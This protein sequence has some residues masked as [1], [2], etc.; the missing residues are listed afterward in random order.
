MK[1][2]FALY[3][4]CVLLSG[5]CS[6]LQDKDSVAS[7]TPDH[8]IRVSGISKDGYTLYLGDRFT[9]NPQI[10]F[11]DSTRA[12]DYDYRWII[13]KNEIISREKNLNWEIALPIDY[14]LNSEIPGVFVVH[15]TV[16]DLEFRQTFTLTL[17]TGYTPEY[18][19]I[20]ETDEGNIEWMS[21]QGT[22]YEWTR[23]YED[24]IERV[25][26]TTVPGPFIGAF[27]STDE[28]A[29]F[30][31]HEPDYG[32]TVSMIDAD[33]DDDFVANVGE[34]V[35]NIY[36]RVYL[37]N[38]SRLDIKDVTYGEGAS[39]YLISNGTLHVFNGL[40]KR[41]PMYDENT[42]IKSTEVAQ[43]VSSKQFM[44][45]KKATFVR[46]NDGRIGCFHTYNDQM[47]WITIGGEPFMLD[48]ICGCFTQATGE[49]SNKPYDV[50]LIG[51]RDNTYKIYRFHVDYIK[52]QVRPIVYDDSFDIPADLVEK[53]HYWFG[54]FGEE[55]A[56]YVTQDAIYRFDYHDMTTFT[57]ATAPLIQFDGDKEILD[58]FI[59]QG[60]TF[61]DEDDCTV[62][63]LY[64][65]KTRKTTLYVYDTVTG[66][67]YA[68]YIDLLPGRG[69]F[70]TAR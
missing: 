63:F 36:G 28:L 26:R 35:G 58:L 25:N 31:G 37:G 30:S 13:G 15:N 23:T 52:T 1:N 60:S 14:K 7:W 45:F 3:I 17:L 59:L 65:T 22:P 11:S 69:V 51:G 49:G 8:V 34:I 21:L 9:C 50:Y 27:N 19:A 10:T 70:F 56:F 20:Y 54:S 66:R 32:V 4:A 12:G 24:M 47:E 48:T 6:C 40:E 46:H 42:Y 43:T 5:L 33:E 62:A 16:N 55:Y 68:E 39:K 2:R 67:K 64:D 18:M 44:R 61:R 38:A 41:L 29:I 53:V 57:P